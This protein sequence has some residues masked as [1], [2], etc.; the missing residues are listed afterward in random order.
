MKKTLFGLF[1]VLLLCSHDMFLK[2]D[3]YFLAPQEEAS[4]QLFNGTFDKSENVIDRNRMLDVSLVGN[5]TR[6]AVD[7]TQWTERDSITFLN[8]TTGNPGTWVAGVSTRPRDI[9]LDAEA[10]N[11]YLEHDGVLDMLA[12][13]KENNL[14][15]QDAVEK[16]SKHVKTLFQVGDTVSTDWKTVLGYPIEFVPMGNPYAVHPGHSLSVQLLFDGKPL[17]D[18]SVYLG[19]DTSGDTEATNATHSHDGG[20]PHTHGNETP[21]HTHTTPN[22][23]RTNADGMINFEL[24]SKGVYHLRTIYMTESEEEGLTHESNWATLTFA[25]GDGIAN[26]S[27]ENDGTHEHGDE[28]HTHDDGFPSYIF[29]IA[30]ILVLG[31]LFFVFTRKK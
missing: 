23:L 26:H 6:T 3:D 4:I 27:H 5:G 2:L 18:Q 19:M 30:S 21:D 17:A 29:W 13:R 16:Y 22:E 25:V 12:Y 10:F 14:M 7:S 20:K 11:S 24:S 8:F 9:A 28:T 1:A 15:E 31:I